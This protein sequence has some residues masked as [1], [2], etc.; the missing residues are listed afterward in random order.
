M[1]F[2]QSAS[3]VSRSKIMKATSTKGA[4]TRSAGHSSGTTQKSSSIAD[5][6]M[7]RQPEQLASARKKERERKAAAT[8]LIRRTDKMIETL[9]N[10]LGKSPIRSGGDNSS[11]AKKEDDAEEQQRLFESALV[12]LNS[13]NSDNAFAHENRMLPHPERYAGP[14]LL[15]FQEHA[16]AWMQDREKYELIDFQR[17]EQ[18]LVKQHEKVQQKWMDEE[19][20]RRKMSPSAK[21]LEQLVKNAV[22]K[23]GD[24]AN[25][26][27]ND[28][29]DNDH[30]HHH[31][32]DDTLSSPSLTPEQQQQQLSKL[33]EK[34]DNTFFWELVSTQQPVA[35][36]KKSGN[37][38][39]KSSKKNNSSSGSF[40]FASSSS[41]SL[42]YQNSMTHERRAQQ[43]AWP[44]GG[45]LA[46][47]PGLGKTIVSM[48]LLSHGVNLPPAHFIQGASPSPDQ[49][50]LIVR[51]S[52]ALLGNLKMLPSMTLIV[53][54]LS[55]MDH[56]RQH[57]FDCLPGFDVHV[58]HVESILRAAMVPTRRG[59]G[60][61]DDDGKNLALFPVTQK[62]RVERLLL[63]L[64]RMV[65]M[66]KL[67]QQGG[68]VPPVTSGGAG[69]VQ[70]IVVITTYAMLRN[71]FTNLSHPFRKIL[72]PNL[73]Q[74]TTTA[75]SS[76]SGDEDLDADFLD[77]DAL[78]VD[79]TS[80]QPLATTNMLRTALSASW[81]RVLLDEAQ[82]VKNAYASSAR[83]VRA[84][85]ASTRW[86][87][88]GTPLQNSL[89]DIHS[90][91][92]FLDVDVWRS[93]HNFTTFVSSRLLEA[94]LTGAARLRR[95][96]SRVCIRQT[97]EDTFDGKPLLALP[98]ITVEIKYIE[99]NKH[100]RDKYKFMEDNAR[101]QFE[102]MMTDALAELE[103]VKAA[104]TIEELNAAVSKR[105][106]RQLQQQQQQQQAADALLVG[107]IFV[108]GLTLMLRLRQLADDARLFDTSR[109]LLDPPS[110][111]SSSNNNNNNNSGTAAQQ[112]LVASEKS[113]EDVFDDADE[114]EEAVTASAAAAAAAPPV[115]SS[116]SSS[117]TTHQPRYYH[118]HVVGSKCRFIAQFVHDMMT[119]SRDEKCV[120]FSQW[121]PMLAL[122][123]QSL[124][125]GT[126]LIFDGETSQQ[127][128]R[129]ALHRFNNDDAPRG[130]RV[131]LVSIMA[132]GTG[133]NLARANNCIICS[134]WWNPA[135]CNQSMMRV[136]RIGQKRPVKVVR[137]IAKDTIEERVLRLQ[138]QKQSLAEI[139]GVGD[140][141][142]DVGGDEPHKKAGLKSKT[143]GGAQRSTGLSIREMMTLIGKSH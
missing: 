42:V 95:I 125:A 106:K 36:S 55:L 58:L 3:A 22:S 131:L 26:N 32:I 142:E 112:S 71:S 1:S 63:P 7:Q 57:V 40:L 43:P 93:R 65:E 92:Q 62:E 39:M 138:Q 141:R 76:S 41:P 83:A 11:G 116:N 19:E 124:P 143:S 64:H 45:I 130:V 56:W 34:S 17:Q 102:Q 24:V 23:C 52:E 69:V 31:H 77:D 33:K 46:L 110:Y 127:N 13:V 128:R 47:S 27:D 140:L 118:T 21:A 107:R 136:H 111:S 105:S 20:R 113:A 35:S 18:E 91:I 117:S 4:T 5:P 139:A 6:A 90:L 104:A 59:S 9:R 78:V 25:E 126:S 30:H 73:K 28:E 29:F 61:V 123:Q 53:C 66:R 133:L 81:D 49:Q 67:V 75:K 137:L 119:R 16:L 89:D 44:R 94:N 50:Q 74:A 99:L 51:E 132:G 88:T 115:T 134:P 129:A 14:K 121:P 135:V 8:K 84:L 97:K 37:I 108:T 60:D 82:F 72:F 68:A 87:L 120:I 96:L 122:I 98:P 86:C 101:T 10:A 114:L 38:K 2:S 80:S 85:S 70:G 100:E 48:A 79:E 15:P 12:A 103:A 54:P 109:L